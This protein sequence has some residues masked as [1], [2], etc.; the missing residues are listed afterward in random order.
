MPIFAAVPVLPF[1]DGAATIAFYKA[2]GFD[3]NDNWKEYLMMKRDEIELHFWK[4][5]DRHI[6]ENSG[7]YLRVRDIEPLYK[8]CLSLGIVHPNG[9]LKDHPWR[10]REFSILDNNGNCLRIGES[11]V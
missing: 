3:V 6:A 1:Q 7:C 2:F 11:L 5:D 4:C 8:E 10:M 9:P